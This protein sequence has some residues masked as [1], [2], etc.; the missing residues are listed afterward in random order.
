ML[1]AARRTTKPLP[2]IQ[3]RWYRKK[4]LLVGIILALA[5]LSA[6]LIIFLHYHNH[7]TATPN[8]TQN[9]GKKTNNTVEPLANL[10]QSPESIIPTQDSS[11]L[12]KIVI[13]WQQAHSFTAAVVVRELTGSSRIASSNQDASMIPAS[14]Y[15]LYVAY[16]ILHGIEQGSYSL[17]TTTSDGNSIQTDLNNM[18]LNSDNDA[19]RTLGFL[20]GW[21]NINALLQ[22]Q[23]MNNTN[24]Y[25][26]VPPSTQPVGDKHSTAT[27]LATML[28]KLYAG[29]LL[30]PS[31]TQLLLT[32][33]KQ[34]HYRE[35]IPA[36][37]P[38]SIAVADKP[39]WLSPADGEAGYTQNDAAIVY[40]PKSTYLLVIM[41]AGSSTQ[42]LATLSQQ[43]YT[44]L[45]S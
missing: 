45:E 2:R 33:M 5:A 21:K 39:G 44:Y 27:D 37:V 29:K 22:S 43:I 34:Q 19:A 40:G 9:A 14:T 3:K 28:S 41:T 25:N 23:G 36:G 30:S 4:P 32:L 20:Y 7:H 18:I 24:L 1:P 17:S 13:S 12:S 16:A 6:T 26:Y 38:A 31:N 15:K 11:G 10:S 8:I 42:P 35:R